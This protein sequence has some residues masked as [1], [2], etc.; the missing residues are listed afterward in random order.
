MVLIT[1]VGQALGMEHWLYNRLGLFSKAW[2]FSPAEFPS[3][4]RRPPTQS[5]IS[6]KESLKLGV[7]REVGMKEWLRVNVPL[8]HTMSVAK[9]RPQT[10][11]INA[12]QGP[13]LDNGVWLVGYVL[14]AFS[15]NPQFPSSL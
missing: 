3:L 5:Y 13:L 7:G 10:Q 1:K 11:R 14:S 15:L 12:I 8:N 4:S 6:V 2:F 9:Q